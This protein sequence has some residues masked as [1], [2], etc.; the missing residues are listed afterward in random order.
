M[1]RPLLAFVA[2][3]AA[4]SSLPARADL[5]VSGRWQTGDVAPI[6]LAVESTS[7]FGL[8]DAATGAAP[9]TTASV[10]FYPAVGAS[11]DDPAPAVV[12]LHGAGGVGGAREGRY[13]REL[14]AQGVAVAVVDVF[15]ARGGG[16]F[17]ERLMRTTEAMALAD[18]FATLDALA[19]RP[20]VDADRVALI[21][22]SYGGMSS[23]YAAYAQVVEAFGA[24]PFA[25]HVA[26]YGPCIARFADPTT[27]GAPVL[28]LW[29]ERDA[30]MDAEACEALA[31]DLRSGGS[32]VT[33]RRFDAMH[34]WD[35]GGRQWRA[36]V[37]I[38][39]C[40]LTVAPDGTVTDDWSG[41]TMSDA[42]M[43]ATILSLC[44]SREGYLIGGDE[45]VRQSSNAALAAFLNPIL[46]PEPD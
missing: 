41:L 28:M 21:G 11:A 27:T 8:S 29:G 18:A 9:P 5:D 30:I 40:R 45:A 7:P 23:I 15:G 17:T 22:F 35:A 13:A 46:F 4:L 24:R 14:A 32:P 26:F 39:E 42:A 25:A 12:L 19:A 3:L 36:P 38:A 10:A 33:V 31:D 43:R 34:R 16:G 20:E 37:H 1:V 44:A 6:R 2:L